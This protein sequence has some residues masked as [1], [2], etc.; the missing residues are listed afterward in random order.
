[1]SEQQG[2]QFRTA[3]FGGFQKQD[4]MTYLEENAQ[5]HAR[6]VALLRK[7]LQDERQARSEDGQ[8]AGEL[9]EKCKALEAE[10]QRLA[11]DLAQREAALAQKEAELAQAE[12]LRAEFETRLNELKG[13]MEK[14]AHAAA[15]YEAVK[16]RTAGIELEAHGRAQQIEEEARR[17]AGAVRQ[18]TAAWFENVKTTY[19][20]LHTDVDQIVGRAVEELHRAGVSLEGLTGT[21]R[22][23]D[24]TMEAFKAKIASLSGPREPQPLDVTPVEEIP[25]EPLFEAPAEEPPAAPA[26]FAPTE[27][28][29]AS[30]PVEEKPS[31]PFFFTPVETAPVQ[32]SPFTS[33]EEPV[34]QPSIFAP[35]P[36][37]PPQPA[38]AAPAEEPAPQVETAPPVEEKPQDPDLPMFTGGESPRLPGVFTFPEDQ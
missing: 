24:E 38:P 19:E 15:A 7:Q 25:A 33:T 11:A 35:A 12:S 36:E 32:D 2:F 22:G 27:E 18:E 28:P 31:Q 5:E 10:S 8:K 29:P 6:Q 14:M 13:Q 9:E 30:A 34:A 16:E 26:F 3:A 4:V 1:M 21:F 20:H 23:Y 37:T 17:Q